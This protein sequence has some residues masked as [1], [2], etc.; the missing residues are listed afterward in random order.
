[1]TNPIRPTVAAVVAAVFAL[2]A[3]LFPGG[4]N[5]QEHAQVHN[6]KVVTDVTPDMTSTETIIAHV[7]KAGD[8][9]EAMAEALR[10][11]VSDARYWGPSQ[12]LNLRNRLGGTDPIMILN[13]SMSTIC[14]QDSEMMIAI[15][16]LMGYSTRMHQLG[17]HTSPEVWY[18]GRWRHFDATF[19]AVTRDKDGQVTTVLDRDAI[20]GVKDNKPW[21][22]HNAY[23]SRTE[24]YVLGHTMGLTLRRG[25]TFTRYWGPLS[26][27]DGYYVPASDGRRPHDRVD[28]K[29]SWMTMAMNAKP[30]P[31]EAP[32]ADATYGNG[33]WVFQP[34]LGA[35]DWRTLCEQVSDLD[36]ARDEQG[37]SEL[38]STRDGK[39]GQVVFRVRSPY[40]MTGGKFTAQVR[41]S[42]KGGI[43][44][45]EGSTDY[46]KTWRRMLRSQSDKSGPISV[47]LANLVCAEF[48]YLLRLTVWPD[49]KAAELGVASLKFETITQANP[50][51]LPALR[52]GKTTVR[53]EAGEQMERI[54]LWPDLEGGQYRQHAVEALNVQRCREAGEMPGWSTGIAAIRTGE[55]SYL[56]LRVDVP[57]DLERL[58]VGG[59]FTVR[60]GRVKMFWSLD[61][62][63]WTELP[64]S[65]KQAGKETRNE[66][67][68][69]I[70]NYE[71]VD[72]FPAGTK[73]AL[74]KFWFA[75]K[76]A[77]SRPEDMHLLS[78]LRID[79][80]YPPPAQKQLPAVEVTYAWQQLNE[81]KWVDKT[82]TQKVESLPAS[83][84]IEV[85]ADEASQP[86]MKWLRVQQ[87][88]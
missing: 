10:S 37:V 67:R 87:A 82:H 11:M 49:D 83:Y 85:Q 17:W 70:A 78:G 38:R 80:Y 34:D 5:G 81:G 76:S 61:G 25:E 48:D 4:A 40:V 9:D 65:F 28:E 27:D 52:P 14:Q 46:G 79:A 22:R 55:E 36:V 45:V 6:L 43:V 1:M 16:N 60:P 2:G 57:R 44:M 47:D 18:E 3:L 64:M 75:P 24:P 69:S 42:G 62:K 41:R 68:S 15:W 7:R 13:C 51:V 58:T 77:D 19:D 29:G 53:V 56:T 26:K 50:F 54:T 59:R 71:T 84:E 66:L 8:S 32:P 23:I 30:R 39:G 73:S 74:V 12:R 86:R 72:S 31:F 20:Y 35:D 21:V 63:E 88:K 33:L